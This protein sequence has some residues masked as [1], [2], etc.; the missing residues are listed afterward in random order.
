M[1]KDIIIKLFVASILILIVNDSYAI[2]SR[3]DYFMKPQIGVWFGPITPMAETGEKL[4]TALGGGAYFRYNAPWKS[5]K[6]GLDISYHNF[7]SQGIDELTCVPIYASF[8]YQIPIDL[9]VRFQLKAGA[10]F[11]WVNIIPDE[12]EQW[13][14]MFMGG[15]EMSF[16]A[17]RSVN[18][19]LRIDYIHINETLFIDGAHRN[20]HLL[21]TGIMVYFNI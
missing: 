21:N 9:P 19:G 5:L 13:D 15:V 10:G 8:I 11:S 17:G 2:K 6:I 3:K 20:G 18:I 1:K 12:W 16:P 14:P 4:E 7:T